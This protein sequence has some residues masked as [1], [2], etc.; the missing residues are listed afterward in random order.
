M[1]AATF[2]VG[3]M[4]RFV[5]VGAFAAAALLAAAA[6]AQDDQKRPQVLEE[7]FECRK[8]VDP[9]QRL[10]CFE[11]AASKMEE[12]EQQG[13][14][15]VV[16]RE[17]AQQA[18]RRAFGFSM[19]NI[20]IFGKKDTGPEITEIHATVQRTWRSPRGYWWFQLDDGSVWKQID[21]YRIPKEP[22]AG[23]KVHV[24]KGMIGNFFIK[25]DGQ[26]QVRVSRV[27]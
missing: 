14:V 15:V 2:E 8:V 22:R 16:D 13:D 19:P 25:V 11:A 7:I 6:H 24:K 17:Q 18:R 12:A 26:Q 10:A 3:K 4:T 1:H 23:S 27:R 20:T 9:S 21:G 5:A